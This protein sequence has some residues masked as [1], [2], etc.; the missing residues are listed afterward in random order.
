MACSV[1]TNYDGTDHSP[2]DEP[3][4]PVGQVELFNLTAE[5]RIFDPS[6]L[7]VDGSVAVGEVDPLPVHQQP[8]RDRV[9]RTFKE[10]Q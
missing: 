8:H 2:I 5:D 10:V 1:L 6:E 3:D 4:S 9:A 7:D